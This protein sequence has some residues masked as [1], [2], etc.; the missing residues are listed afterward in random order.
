MA[1][2]LSALVHWVLIVKP[3]TAALWEE[4]AKPQLLQARLLPKPVKPTPAPEVLLPS[5]QVK[6]AAPEEVPVEIEPKAEPLPAPVAEIDSLKEH[7]PESAIEPVAQASAEDGAHSG[8]LLQEVIEPLV[9]E[10]DAVPVPYAQIETVFDV[11]VNREQSRAGTSTIHYQVL[12]DQ[13]YLLEWKVKATGLL[14]LLYPNLVQTSE[15]KVTESGL[16][17][18]LYRY[19]FGGKADKTREAEFNW[20]DKVLS[21]RTSKEAKMADIVEDA[22]DVLSF[23]YQFMFVPPLSNMQIHITNGKKLAVYDYAFEGEELLTLKWGEVKTY[24]ITHSKGDSDEKTELWLAVDYQFVP[25]KIRK[26][27]KKGMVI[28]QVATSLSVQS[29]TIDF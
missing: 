22:Q 17:P 9:F 4:P 6:Q 26:T 5:K 10:S 7:V 21:L 13:R 1:I 15:G 14:G 8:E 29:P 28:E 20:S 23:M 27:E 2:I 11:F 19:Q 24:H 25:V 18:Q 12:D 16:K 3:D